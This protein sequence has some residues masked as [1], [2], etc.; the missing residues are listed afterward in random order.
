MRLSLLIVFI[1][2]GGVGIFALQNQNSLQVRFLKFVWETSQ[3][4][5]I[6]AS[7]TL[8]LIGG[9]LAMVPG[10]IRRWRKLRNLEKIVANMKKHTDATMEDRES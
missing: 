6:M 10:S 3:S 7:V 2:I 1:V 4:I 8:G 9:I 5:V